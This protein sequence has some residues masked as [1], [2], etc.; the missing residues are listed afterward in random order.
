[1]NYV[2][3]IITSSDANAF[4]GGD[5][6]PLGS[7]TLGAVLR[8][9]ALKHHQGDIE[10]IKTIK[11]ET[12][13]FY[14]RTTGNDYARHAKEYGIELYILTAPR[15]AQLPT[16]NEEGWVALDTAPYPV[17][18][19]L[20][21]ASETRV[22]SNA[23]LRSTI[24][25]V[26]NSS[27][28]RWMD[29]FCSIM[30]RILPWY[31]SDGISDD[32]KNLFKAINDKNEDMFRAII[33]NLCAPYDFKSSRFRKVLIGWNDGYRTRQI[34]LLKRQCDEYH[35]SI[36][37]YQAEITSLLNKLNQ[38][39]IN[40]EALQAQG[41]SADDSVYKF[42]MS[43]RQ[44]TICNTSQGNDGNVM[45]FSVIET[46]EYFDAD[47]F[48]RLYNNQ[49]S[50]IG[51]ASNDIK[52]IFYGVFAEN[53]G[54]FR[55]EGM[56]RLVN[57]S[58]LNARRGYVSGQFND[59]HL[60]HPHLYHHACLGGN[61][62]YIN[63]YMEQ[64]NWD[65]AIEQTIAAVKNINFGDSTVI[66]EFVDDVRNAFNTSRKCILADNGKEMTLREFLAY[67]RENQENEGTENG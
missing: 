12:D 34:S 33:D 8:F 29:M 56:F 3:T 36:E 47:A 57:L 1:M 58:S 55:V 40:L 66:R 62:G 26:R 6:A 49:H 67:V 30:F 22:Y 27:S 59:T 2:N 15:G 50:T 64:G 65:M 37:R 38:S 10:T 14:E 35:S 13:Q 41:N 4:F 25:F 60:P 16:I 28:E 63:S 19:Y 21:G 7:F 23:A 44:I 24:V 51:G 11:C 18:P 54:V 31:F 20:S 39:S 17:A 53:K 32:E 52:D 43:H 61:E 46:I 5:N 48:L 9:I 45:D 42:F